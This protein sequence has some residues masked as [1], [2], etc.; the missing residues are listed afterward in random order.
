MRAT[1]LSRQLRHPIPPPPPPR[2]PPPP[3]CRNMCAARLHNSNVSGVVGTGTDPPFP[4]QSYVEGIQFVGKTSSKPECRIGTYPLA[5]ATLTP[6]PLKYGKKVDIDHLHVSLAH[7]PASV[8]KAPAKQ[9]GIRLTGEL[10]SC[11][12]CSRAKGIE[13]LLHITQRGERS[14]SWDLSTSTPLSLIQLLLGGRGTS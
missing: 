4:S 9:R 12:A 3:P 6:G 7:F 11:S 8:L 10:V 5:V 14:S 1:N 2:E 13:H